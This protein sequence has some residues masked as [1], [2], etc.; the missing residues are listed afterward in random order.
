M[1]LQQVLLNTLGASIGMNGTPHHKKTQE[2]REW[3]Y[4]DKKGE[5][6][7]NKTMRFGVRPHNAILQLWL[8]LGFWGIMSEFC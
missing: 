4:F 5:L 8:E 1:R 6:H 3:L 2:S 7:K